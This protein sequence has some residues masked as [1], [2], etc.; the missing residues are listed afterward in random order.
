M[1]DK[2]SAQREKMVQKQLAKRDIEDP[3]VL[4]AFRKVPREEFIT[5]SKQHQAYGDHP[6]P[7]GHGQTISQPYIV[8]MM[9]QALEPSSHDIVLEVGTGSGYQTAI[10][11]ELTKK[12]F[13]LERIPEL[14]EQAGR[15]L[16]KLGYQNIVLK[17]SDDDND[18]TIHE[19]KEFD[20]II[21]T[22]A[23]SQIPP[24]LTQQLKEGGTLVIPVGELMFQE[25]LVVTKHNGELRKKSLG[26]CRFVP[27]K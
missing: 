27:L 7:I 10:L 12:V 21:V 26:G 5:E 9:T 6:L 13:S 1:K 3:K 16:S 11:A 20:K 15:I 23:A 25:L 18:L 8:A 4:D 2:F 24:E 22:A 14:S 17:I 19:Q